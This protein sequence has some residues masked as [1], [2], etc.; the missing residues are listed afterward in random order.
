VLWL[1]KIQVNMHSVCPTLKLSFS[2]CPLYSVL[3]YTVLLM[4]FL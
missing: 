3:F 1:R 4:Q 2:V